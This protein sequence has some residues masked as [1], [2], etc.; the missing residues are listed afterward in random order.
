MT[1]FNK[2]VTVPLL[3]NGE[4]EAGAGAVTCQGNRTDQRQERP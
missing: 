2:N 4:T 3:T 1:A